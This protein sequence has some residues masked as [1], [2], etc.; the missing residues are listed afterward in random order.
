VAAQ[1]AAVQAKA[2]KSEG[3]RAE[4]EARKTTCKQKGPGRRLGMNMTRKLKPRVEE[5]SEMP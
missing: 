3:E 5:R 4:N 1:A 2:E